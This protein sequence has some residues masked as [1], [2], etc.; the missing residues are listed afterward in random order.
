MFFVDGKVGG[1]LSDFFGTTKP[2]AKRLRAILKLINAL[3]P[4]CGSNPAQHSPEFEQWHALVVANQAVA[5]EAQ[6]ETG[7]PKSRSRHLCVWISNGSAS[8]A[9]ERTSSRRTRRPS[10]FSPA[11]PT[12][13]SSAS[14]L[15]G[16]SCRVQP[17]LAAHRLPYT[18]SPHRRLEHPGTETRRLPRACC[19]AGLHPNQVLSRRPHSLLLS[20]SGSRRLGSTRRSPFQPRSH[21]AGCRYRRSS[22]SEKGFLSAQLRLLRRAGSKP[23]IDRAFR[24]HA[25]QLLRRRQYPPHRPLHRQAG[26]RPSHAQA[27]PNRRK[28]QKRNQ[29]RLRL[30]R[31]RQT[32]WLRHRRLP[33]LGY[34]QLPRRQAAPERALH[35]DRC[36]IRYQRKL[37]PQPRGQQLCY[38]RRRSRRRQVRRC[39]QDAFARHLERLAPE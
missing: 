7:Q 34:I 26:I 17:R 36:R 5:V 10:S 20:P 15:R 11:I 2:E 4:G 24:H 37:R 23:R 21:D 19:A 22:L 32:S 18:R 8:A 12:S 33:E 14:T 31:Q 27:D 30:H 35:T 28:P 1:K 9:T 38:R 29:R 25:L 39:L 13:F 3:P 16:S 6:R